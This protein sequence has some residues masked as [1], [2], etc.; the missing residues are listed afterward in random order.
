RIVSFLERFTQ[1]TPYTH[2]VTAEISLGQE[3]RYVPFPYC[4]KTAECLGRQLSREEI[5]D[6]F[7]RGYSQKMWGKPWEALPQSIQ[8]RV[9]KDTADEPSYYRDQFVALPR[10][11]YTRMLENMLDGVE[12]LL[13]A[14]PNEWTK[15][16]ARTTVYTGRP[17]LIPIP[18]EPVSI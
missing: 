5:I 9:P 16:S 14:P 12:L 6:A 3:F 7:Y 18:D 1:W 11:G 15:I 8:A 2:K 4:K 10:H 17:D 13:A